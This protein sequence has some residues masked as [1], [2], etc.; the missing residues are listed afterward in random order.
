MIVEDS[1]VVRTLLTHI[2][3]A[4]PRLTVALAVASAEE[5]LEVLEEVKPDV[6]SMDI[7]LPGMDGLEATRRIM[8]EHPTPIV[9]IADSVEELAEDLA[10]RPAR[11]G[12]DGG[13]EAGGPR[14]PGL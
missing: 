5:A 14:Q 11:R 13:G 4:D 9:V 12:A 10:E 2:I 1:A 3:D 6:I 7:R 8:A